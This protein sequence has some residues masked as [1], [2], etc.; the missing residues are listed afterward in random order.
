[1]LLG[2][3]A[4]LP[5][6]TP[7][8]TLRSPVFIVSAPFSGETVLYN[9]LARASGVWRSRT[10]DAT[11]LEA[12]PDIDPAKR[13][14]S[15][16]AVGA[17][18]A[19]ALTQAV[20]DRLIETLVDRE[21]RS[22]DAA[23]EVRALAG[24]AR[25]ALRVPL[26]AAAFLD[27]RFV[28]SF[29]EPAAAI[30][31]MLAAWRSGRFVS[32]PELP[33]WDGPAWSLPLIPG[34]R[35]LTGLPL[36]EVVV[37]QWAAITELL[38]DDLEALAPERW[39]A[40]DLATLVAEPRAELQRLCGFLD[41]PYDQALLTPVETAARVLTRQ[42]T[43]PAPELAAHLHRTTA[44]AGRWE[45]LVGARPTAAGAAPTSSGSSPF[46]SSSTMSFARLLAGSRSSLLVSTYQ[47]GK[48][49][50]AREQRGLLN[51]HFR[52]FD[53]PMG[54]AVSRGRFALATR[55]EVWDYRDMP[56]VA[57]KLEPAG[58]H[59]ACYLP[60]NRHHTGDALMH[61]MA[62]AGG[63]LWVVATRFSCLATL[64]SDHS[65]VP[66]WKPP[67]VTG[68]A[69]GDRC[70]LNG[71]A[72]KDDKVSFV[73]AL[74]QTDGPG[75]WREHK[76]TGGCLIDIASSEIVCAGLSMPHSPRW[77][78]DRLWL[79]E[80]GRGEL[81]TI[82]LATGMTETVVELP[83]FTRGLAF[84]GGYAFVGLSQIRESSTFGDLPL[85]NRLSERVC[86]VW[87]IELR[88]GQIAGFLRFEDIVQEIF[89]VALL[90]GARFP[91]IAD[92]SS[93]AASESFVL[94]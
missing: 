19:P 61:E 38:L 74:G 47:S 72:V 1:M 30:A 54:M 28:V 43:P 24:G 75:A 50:C 22:P 31:E 7:M 69:G 25:L 3:G 13:E 21:D 68:V 48:L 2:G 88:S 29:R 16:H 86:G 90:P 92:P 89:D 87:I 85:T 49:I 8:P 53:K 45:E 14:W 34:W 4:K 20:R 76:A 59:D 57:P 93:S 64:D 67:F 23:A 78:D 27:A 17:D 15:S 46:R 63:E 73:T 71:L 77:H 62:F 51:T 65:F 18:E 81:T 32:C 91:E 9:A 6:H 94:P 52:D 41:I 42:A 83:G 11:F 79:L 35:D 26:L 5:E 80:S 33:G 70:H 37:A 44:A 84:A 82:D 40:C 60:R 12:L 10:A 66:R 56:E 36:E 58:T 55:T 39:A